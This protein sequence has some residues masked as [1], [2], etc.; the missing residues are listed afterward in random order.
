MDSI[1]FIFGTRV[2]TYISKNISLLEIYKLVVTLIHRYQ[3]DFTWLMQ[4]LAL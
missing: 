2:R 3:F 4:E 1:M